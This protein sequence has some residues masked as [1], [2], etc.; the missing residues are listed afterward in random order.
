MGL[1]INNDKHPDV[2]KNHEQITEKNQ[3]IFKKDHVSELLEQQYLANEVLQQSFNEM[4]EQ[5]DKQAR[6]QAY[7]W[8]YFGNRL[9]ELKRVSNKQERTDHHV[10]DWLKKLE[11]NNTKMQMNF[12]NDL[13][14]KNQLKESILHLNHSNQDVVKRIDKIGLANEEMGQKVNEQLE[15]QKKMSQQ[16]SAQEDKQVDVEQR[17]KNQEALSEKV[18]RQIEHFRSVLFERTNYLAEKIDTSYSYTT[19]YFTKLMNGNENLKTRLINQKQK[20]NQKSTE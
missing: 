18:L 11:E 15:L 19:S 5:L 12:D 13:Q 1:F 8:K 14:V 7:H 2:Y 17:L 16:I 9:Y 6:K 20:E 4:K 10:M 3:L